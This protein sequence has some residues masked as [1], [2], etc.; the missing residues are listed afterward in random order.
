MSQLSITAAESGEQA[1]TPRF[2]LF[3]GSTTSDAAVSKAK[4]AGIYYHHKMLESRASNWESI[5]ELLKAPNLLGVV[6]KLTSRNFE[7]MV[8][9]DYEQVGIALLEAIGKT[10]HVLFVHESILTG[11][12]PWDAAPAPDWDGDQPP[13]FDYRMRRFSPPSETTRLVVMERLEKYDI[14]VTPYKTNAELSML[15]TSFIDAN[16]NN[17]LF[18]L[19]VPSGRLY[20]GEAS[21]MVEMFREW[22]TR[23][24][25]LRIRE[26]GYSTVRG[27]VYEFFGDQDTHEVEIAQ[28]F[29]DF[30][31]FLET[32]AEAPDDAISRLKAMGLDNASAED[33]V[34]RYGKE[35]RRL[36]LDLRHARETKVMSIQHRL[37]SELV[38]Q[39]EAKLLLPEQAKALVEKLVPPLAK[40]SLALDPPSAA[41][42]RP[43]GS[44]SVVV[45]QQ[46]IGSVEGIVAQELH[47]TAHLGVQSQELITLIDRFGAKEL[48]ALQSAVHE[49]ED[50]EARPADRL[51]AKQR[52][53]GFLYKLQ[54]KVEDTALKVLQKYIEEKA[55]LS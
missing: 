49:I 12:D 3:I 7:L 22:L 41:E 47:G 5:V 37:E 11:E 1:E 53:K 52:L 15:A 36:H 38:D 32:C 6:A 8:Q 54:G 19:Y 9:S 2:L 33:I 14:N 23:V 51:A 50:T 43:S 42:A 28:E 55:G 44:P 25:R 18:R 13:P 24:K 30:S 45:N 4:T 21:K 31:E 20:A 40:A 26:D 27:H 10:E 16:E 35:T 17:L 39:A 46:I 29:A 48:A 34:R